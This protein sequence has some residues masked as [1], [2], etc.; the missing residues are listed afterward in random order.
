MRI[1]VLLL[2]LFAAPAWA[3]V[4]FKGDR[5]QGGLLIGQAVPGSTVTVEG[6]AIRVSKDG[7]FLVG[8][9]RKAPK[10]VLV[11]VNG[12][13]Y[14]IGVKQRDYKIQ[15]IDGLPK[16]KVTP[17]PEAIKRI[18]ADNAKIK[19]V[20]KL[21]TDFPFF[22]AS[23]R[24]PVTGRISG[25]FGS[26]R[27]LNGKPRSPHNGVDIAAPTGTPIVAMTDGII[28]LVHPD[29]FYTGQTVMIDHGHG[30]TSVYVHMSKTYVK[31]GQK[32]LKGDVIGEVGMTGRATGPH[33]HWGVSLFGTHLDPA[34]LVGPM[35]Q[36]KTKG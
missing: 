8:F 21:D 10:Q 12:K 17:D 19:A 14:P 18:K 5:E 30:L 1:L 36:Q 25:V 23:F 7:R 3:E 20:R 16:K 28:A 26:Q 9:G 11:M 27:I 29:M 31:E 34:L 2:C 6:Q 35:P 15:R 4:S 22:A 13:A 24:W 32:V 33:L